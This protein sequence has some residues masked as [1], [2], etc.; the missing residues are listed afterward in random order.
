MESGLNKLLYS[1]LRAQYCALAV[2][3]SVIALSEACYGVLFA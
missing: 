1:L 2:M 3:L